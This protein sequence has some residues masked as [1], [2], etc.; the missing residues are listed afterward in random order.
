MPTPQIIFDTDRMISV[1]VC[2]DNALNYID[3]TIFNITFSLKRYKTNKNG[4]YDF[5]SNQNKEL[6]LCNKEDFP[7]EPNL[8]NEIGLRNAYCLKSKDFILEGFWDE[9]EIVFADLELFPCDNL[10]M[11]YT[12]KS[13]DEINAY[14]TGKK[15]FQV[16]FHG[17]GV[18]IDDYLRNFK[19]L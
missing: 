4:S 3:P 17:V 9:Q 13:N 16:Y 10:T 14:F 7:F 11:N 19:F 18:K 2:D 12:C 15:Y 1:S 5:V 6:K 8:L